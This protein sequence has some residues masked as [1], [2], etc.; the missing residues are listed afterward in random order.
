MHERRVVLGSLMVAAILVSIIIIGIA[1]SPHHSTVT[2]STTDIFSTSVTQSTVDVLSTV[3][4]LCAPESN[5]QTVSSFSGV[6]QMV[7]GNPTSCRVYDQGSRAVPTSWI[8]YQVIPV[9]VYAPTSTILTLSAPDIPPDSWAHFGTNPLVASP[10]GANTTLTVMGVVTTSQGSGSVHNLTVQAS[11]PALTVN[12][13]VPVAWGSLGGRPLTVLSGE[14]AEPLFPTSES[15]AS[16]VS[17]A[18]SVN[19]VYDPGN[20]SAAPSSLSVDLKVLGVVVD[21]SVKSMPSTLVF[22][23]SKADFTLAPYQPDFLTID[24][25]N[26]IPL[27]PTSPPQRFV[28]AVAET[29][30][31]VEATQDLALTIEPP[32]N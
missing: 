21:G 27:G 15:F 24:E 5:Q 14:G 2:Q 18:S 20:V 6:P 10:A 25:S 3:D 4:I 19:M 31:G 23:F 32:V 11:S 7:I 13:T 29:V 8:L 28:V 9:T 17:S 1:Q 12:S 26:T 30:N 16:N 22:S